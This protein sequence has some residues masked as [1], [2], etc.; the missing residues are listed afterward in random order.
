VTLRKA[1]G[2]YS[3]SGKFLGELLRLRVYEFERPE[4]VEGAFEDVADF[5]ATGMGGEDYCYRGF[6]PL[7]RGRVLLTGFHGDKIWELHGKPDTVLARGGGLSGASLQEFRLWK[8]F[9]HVPVPMIGARRHPEIAAI[10]QAPEMSAYQLH[11]NYDRPIPR[12]ILEQAGVPRALFG[13]Y[14][15]AASLLLFLDP[16]LLGPATRRECEA[17]VPQQWVRAAQRGPARA[18]WELRYRGY[19]LLQR[20]GQQIPGSEW[21]QRALI[22][23]WEVFA[24]SRPQAALEFLAGL[25][26]VAGRYQKALQGT[27]PC[28]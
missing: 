20:H 1:R 23:D 19:R 4:A 12:R 7:L 5:L 14:K 21:L 24:H 11:N 3:D 25:Q 28:F 13:Q 17:M 22:G 15:K 18:A 6:D 27:L 8:N 26:V 16:Q 2:G 10:S 9:I